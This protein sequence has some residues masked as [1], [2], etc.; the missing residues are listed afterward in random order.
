M[1]LKS[2]L[3]LFLGINFKPVAQFSDFDFCSSSPF[4]CLNLMD[5]C[6]FLN[7]TNYVTKHDPLLI[8]HSVKKETGTHLGIML[9]CDHCRCKLALL[10]KK[11]SLSQC[12]TASRRH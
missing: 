1:I 6:L 7:R 2:I 5:I 8:W 10:E 11:V 12:A 3:I 4:P 9:V